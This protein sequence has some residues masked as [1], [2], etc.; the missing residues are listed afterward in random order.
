MNMENCISIFKETSA[1][2]DII[3]ITDEV[4]DF[5]NKINCKSG[6]MLVFINGSTA[7]VSTIEYEPGLIKDIKSALTTLFPP[8]K[9]YEHHKTWNDG[10]GYSH[11]M[12]TFMKPSITIPIK[13]GKLILGTWQQIILL[14]FD[15][16]PRK[17]EVIL[18]ILT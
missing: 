12:A 13:N 9:N 3:N 10:N 4:V 11:I 8:N 2:I 1:S 16:K 17:R 6:A 5:V 7:S 15:N 14:D 18:K